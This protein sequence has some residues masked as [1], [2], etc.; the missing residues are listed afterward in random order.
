MRKFTRRQTILGIFTTLGLILL[1]GLL[2]F[3]FLSSRNARVAREF[4]FNF[5]NG[6]GNWQAEISDYDEAIDVKT[7][8]FKFGVE[9]NP[10][11]ELSGRYLMVQSH[12]R[13]DDLFTFIHNKL[14][15]LLPNT[16]YNL[17]VEVE[18]AS[19]APAD[20]IGIGGSPATSVF[21]KAGGVAIRPEVSEVDSKFVAN[22]DHGNQSEGSTNFKVLGNL[23]TSRD[24]G[25]YEVIDLM[26]DNTSIIPVKTDSEGQLV[27][28]LGTDSG[29]EGLTKVYYKE[30]KLKLTPQ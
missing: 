13:S 1:A 10:E 6:I 7:L 9:T 26:T 12:N 23:A 20:A 2:G 18:V 16:N 25:K 17:S 27:I 22:F 19:N 29:F 11:K 24:D 4:T 21:F 15:G 30:I 3:A 28:V 5:E 14:S 8:E